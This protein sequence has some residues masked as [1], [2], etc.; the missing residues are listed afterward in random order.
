MSVEIIKVTSRRELK[1]FVNYPNV[2]YKGNPYYV[3]K[4][5]VDEIALFDRKKNASFEFCDSDCFLAYRNGEIVGRVA[6]I[7]N[8]RANDEWGANNV[9]FGWID[10][11]DD[12][13][14]SSALLDA[15]VKWGKERGVTHIEGPLGFTDF[16]TEGMLVDGFDKLG[17]MVTFYN[18]PYYM[19]HMERLGYTKALDWQEFLL[20]VPQE[21]P[22][23][24]SR[25]SDLLLSKYK[26]H[27]VKLSMKNLKARY[28]QKMFDLINKTYCVLYGYSFLTQKQI[29][30]YIRQYLSFLDVRMCSFIVDNNDEVVAFGISMPSMSRAL[31]KCGGKLLPFGWFHLLKALKFSNSNTM[32]LLLVAVRPDFQKRG[33]ASLVIYDM[34]PYLIKKGVRFA[35]SN[36]E[37][38]TNKAVQNMWTGFNPVNHKRRRIYEKDI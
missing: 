23:R 28:G 26:L 36:P 31:Q 27:L 32:D 19:E 34:L 12:I 38:E 14:V 2:L 13:E 33:I 4:L 9:R 3:P 11:I 29:D 15:V 35:E 16:D 7:I 8:P 10:F 6:A 18:H 1:D 20:D 30:Q 21:M 25:A 22:E 5:F 17:T 24:Y 37:L